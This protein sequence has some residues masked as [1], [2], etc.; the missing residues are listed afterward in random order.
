MICPNCLRD[1]CKCIDSRRVGDKRTRRYECL[2][3]TTRVQTMEEI[4]GIRDPGR[5]PTEFDPADEAR[6]QRIREVWG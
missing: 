4:I 1:N 3:C 2:D 5:G 6:L